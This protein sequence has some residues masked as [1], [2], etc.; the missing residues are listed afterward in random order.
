LR[1]F[2]LR[3]SHIRGNGENKGRAPI[4]LAIHP[5]YSIVKLCDPLYDRQSQTGAVL[6][7]CPGISRP[8][9]IVEYLPEVFLRNPDPAV[10]DPGFYRIF[11]VSG[12][13]GYGYA[14]A[15][16]RVAQGI[17]EQVME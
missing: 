5:D 3:A 2:P 12:F 8:V 14:F 15:P 7:A 16:G 10:G 1:R 17:A 11:L 4:Y 13:Q 6:R 9:E